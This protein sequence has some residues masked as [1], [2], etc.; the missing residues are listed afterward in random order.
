[1]H[2]CVHMCVHRSI[3]T[4]AVAGTQVCVCA[5]VCVR[6][7]FFVYVCVC[8]VP[9][10]CSFMYTSI[11]AYIQPEVVHTMQLDSWHL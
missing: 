6:V 8:S 5:S 1:M 2:T 3:H 11:H 7:C 10:N 4:V 9:P